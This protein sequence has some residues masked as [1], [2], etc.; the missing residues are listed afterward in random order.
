M[1][2]LSPRPSLPLLLLRACASFATLVTPLDAQFPP[3]SHRMT[4]VSDACDSS[5]MDLEMLVKR[6]KPLE[7][8]G[9]RGEAPL[10]SVH[11][12]SARSAVGP[13]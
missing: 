8:A 5:L 2:R 9:E 7:H 6:A 10:G 1:Q 4:R 13:R 11:T 3:L 12:T